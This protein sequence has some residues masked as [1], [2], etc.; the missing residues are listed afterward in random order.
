MT[1]RSRV[2]DGIRLVLIAGTAALAAAIVGAI[3]RID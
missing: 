3:L 1:G 2:R